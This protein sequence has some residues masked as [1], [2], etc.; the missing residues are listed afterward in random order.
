MEEG[1]AATAA[2]GEA[3]VS[4]ST[5]RE[6][7]AGS[8]P[9]EGLTLSMSTEHPGEGVTLVISSEYM[10]RFTCFWSLVASQV[11]AVTG[12]PHLFAKDRVTALWGRVPVDT[13]LEAEASVDSF[14]RCLWSAVLG[15]R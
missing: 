5:A 1:V 6:A 15:S 4:I 9:T 14:S 7:E 3:E 8:V 11:G 12:L 13:D 10:L 2:A